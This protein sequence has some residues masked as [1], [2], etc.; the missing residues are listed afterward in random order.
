MNNFLNRL[1]RDPLKSWADFKIGL[2]IFVVGG[3]LIF[4]GLKVGIW[5]QIPG[6]VL[7]AV[8]FGFAAKGYV[9]IFANRFASTL[10][11]LGSAAEQDKRNTPP[12]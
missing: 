2:V 7:L 6:L 1:G 12:D 10:N 8:G 9:G 3:C 5:L 11:R 4:A